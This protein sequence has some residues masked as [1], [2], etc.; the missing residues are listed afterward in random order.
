MKAIISRWQRCMI[1]RDGWNSVF[2]ENHDNPRSVSRYTDDS[3]EYRDKGAKL[4]ALMQTTLG[5]TL[6]VYQGEEIGMRNAPT[7]WDISAE[8]KDI[9]TINY[10]KKCQ[11]IYQD[12]PKQLEHGKKIIQMKA[13]D[14]ARTPMQW[15][16]LDNAGFCKSG[17]EPWMRVMDDF[18]HGINAADQMKQDDD[19]QLSTWQFWQRGIHDRKKHADVFVYG[20]YQEI[21]PNDPSIFAYGRTSQSGERWLVVLNFSGKDVEWTLPS[22]LTVDFWACSTYTK[23]RPEKPSKGQVPLKP[24]EGLLARCKVEPEN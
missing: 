6:F 7:E 22:T 10:W 8:Y 18:T 5:G 13:R 21:S 9:E 12:N 19:R 24:W 1:E 17:V 23:G 14:H 3:D 15:D 11:Q 20:D 16:S 2:I 4:L